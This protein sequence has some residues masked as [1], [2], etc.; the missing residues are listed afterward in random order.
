MLFTCS[1]SDSS[2]LVSQALDP[3]R[4]SPILQTMKNLIQKI[5]V[6]DFPTNMP[7]FQ[8]LI[9]AWDRFV[10]LKHADPKISSALFQRYAYSKTLL[11][12]WSEKALNLALF[13]SVE[14]ATGSFDLFCAQHP[15]LVKVIEGEV[16]CTHLQVP[17]T[18]QTKTLDS[19]YR[20]WKESVIAQFPGIQHCVLTKL[21]L[22]AK[23]KNSAKIQQFFAPF[24]ELYQAAD[25]DHFVT[26]LFTILGMPRPEAAAQSSSFSKS[27]SPV[28]SP[29]GALGKFRVKKEKSTRNKHSVGVKRPPTKK[30]QKAREGLRSRNRPK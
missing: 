4:P 22:A 25:V 17:S 10:M 15:A 29:K 21:D 20:E 1:V 12:L 27:S 28:A 9:L 30:Q 23:A 14:E 7:K 3:N 18:V 11:S 2:R 6:G 24:Y 8:H 13:S 26:Q 16:P 19:V 5:M